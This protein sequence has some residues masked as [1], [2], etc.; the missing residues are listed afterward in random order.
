MIR[1]TFYLVHVEHETDGEVAV[2]TLAAAK[3]LRRDCGATEGA[4][5][6]IVVE[7]PTIREFACRVFN[8]SGFA[9]VQEQIAPD[10]PST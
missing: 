1:T 9:Q 6:R 3:A 8:R 7:I 4:I 5:T 2:E 10:K